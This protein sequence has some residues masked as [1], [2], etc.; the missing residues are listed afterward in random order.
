MMSE[1]ISPDWDEKPFEISEEE[2]QYFHFYD[3]MRV[4]SMTN[5]IFDIHKDQEKPSDTMYLSPIIFS[6]SNGNSILS[7]SG[8]M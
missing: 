8:Q 1:G 7:Y 3:G 6:H 4:E 5:A 2:L